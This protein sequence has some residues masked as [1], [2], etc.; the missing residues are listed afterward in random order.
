MKSSANPGAGRL[1]SWSIHGE[2]EC[3]QCAPHDEP[4]ETKLS[5]RFTVRH[6]RTVPVRWSAWL[7]MI[8]TT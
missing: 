3:H 7:G 6:R 5:G 4:N 8:R 1:K 2:P